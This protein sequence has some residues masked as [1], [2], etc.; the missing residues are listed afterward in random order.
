MQWLIGIDEAG[1]GP[2]LGPLV[3]AAVALRVAD[4]DANPW[5]Q[6]SEQVKRAGGRD[7]GRIL[8]DDSKKVNEGVHGFARLERGT[9]AM[10]SSQAGL[11]LTLGDLLKRTA[12]GDSRDDLLHEAWFDVTQQLP[13]DVDAE[14]TV[15]VGRTLLA[16]IERK[17]LT[18]GPLRT[19]VTPTPRFNM[20]LGKWGNKSNVLGRGVIALLRECRR[21]PGDEPITFLID[22]LGGRN[23]YAA[24]I[25]EAFPDGWCSAEREGPEIC[26]Y[27]ILGVNRPTRLVIQPRADGAH[28]TVALASMFAK[29]LREV[30]M[31]EFNTWWAGQVPGL[32]PTAGYPADAVRYMNAIRPMIQQ[33]GFDESAIWRL[34]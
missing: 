7:D 11:P 33:L 13:A 27:R 23:Y 26:S 16:A 30:F 20:L 22:K 29:Y 2:N 21:L 31:R 32:A 28:F 3:Q 24:M 8:I 12:I 9:L 15:A 1:Y 4:D 14:A 34:K 6:L 18:V 17:R 25:Q 19:L 5:E 10:L